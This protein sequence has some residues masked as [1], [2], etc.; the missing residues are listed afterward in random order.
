VKGTI[1]NEIDQTGGII[2]SDG[3][4][5][6]RSQ[7]LINYISVCTQGEV[8][9]DSSDTSGEEKTSQYIADEIIKQITAVGSAKVIQVLTDSA[10]NCKACWP[11][12]AAKFPHIT[13]GPCTTHCLDLLL[14]DMTKISWIK[15]SFHEGRDIVTFI[16]THH[17][18]RAIFR[19]HSSLELLKPN[20]TR[21][22]TEFIS[23]CRLAHVE[24]SLQETVVDKMYKSWIQKQ[25]YKAKGLEISARMLDE[26]WWKRA[27]TCSNPA[28]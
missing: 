17:K 12:V 19:S 10:S 2:V 6:V 20:D 21:F 27:S 7:P 8:F 18:S 25:K 26:E 11:I 28:L 24:D 13:C 9:L 23:H 5:N 15:G 1:L 22:C 4:S 16:T 3:W 14:E